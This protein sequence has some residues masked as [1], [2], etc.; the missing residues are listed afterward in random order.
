MNILDY[1]HFTCWFFRLPILFCLLHWLQQQSSVFFPCREKDL[2]I[3]ALNCHTNYWYTSSDLIWGRLLSIIQ[4]QREFYILIFKGSKTR[5]GLWRIRSEPDKNWHP[6]L[7]T[8][9]SENSCQQSLEIISVFQT[10]PIYFK[11]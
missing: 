11:L 5:V 7:P 2:T 8:E 3:T 10:M 9:K 6:L 1:L 4:S